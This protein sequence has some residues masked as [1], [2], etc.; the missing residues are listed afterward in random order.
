MA[1][2]TIQASTVLSMSMLSAVLVACGGGGGGSDSSAVPSDIAR[3]ECAVNDKATGKPVADASVSYQAGSKEYLTQTK[4]S[5]NCTLDLPAAEVAG[6]NYPAAS[7]TKP[8][9]EPQTLL[10]SSLKGGSACSQDVALVPLASNVSIP[11]GGGTVMHLGDDLFEG[12]A[13]SQFQ[14]ASDG[15][16]VVFQIPDW[17]DQVKSAGITKATVYL[18]AKGWQSD[19]C[20]NRISLAGDVGEPSQRGGVSPADGYWAGGRQVPFEFKVAEV[21]RQQA[22]LR[23][24]SGNCSGTTDLDDFEINRVRIEF[25]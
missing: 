6:V 22:E 20:A 25:N 18:D 5:G 10:C 13:N 8:G 21:G 4:A 7:V 2:G 16:L 17:A 3:I 15:P 19:I 9:Y 24:V 1:G 12:A 11:L 23:V 14:K